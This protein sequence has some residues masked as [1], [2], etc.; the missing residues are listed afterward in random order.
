MASY[1]MASA[2]WSGV[3]PRLVRALASAPMSSSSSTASAWP[4][5][6]AR[7]SGLCPS[8]SSHST[9]MHPGPASSAIASPWPL[10]AARC[11]AVRPYWSRPRTP[12]RLLSRDSRLPRSPRLAAVITSSHRSRTSTTSCCTSAKID[13]TSAVTLITLLVFGQDKNNGLAMHA[14][15]NT[16]VR[17]RSSYSTGPFLSWFT[18]TATRLA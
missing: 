13:N 2:I 18:S 10:I 7:W 5:S 9:S 3:A 1:P 15:A 12:A 8:T 16:I 4:P 6:T 14:L 17:R 11:S